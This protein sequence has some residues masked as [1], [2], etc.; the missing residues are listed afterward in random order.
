MKITSGNFNLDLSAQDCFKVAALDDFKVQKGNMILYYSDSDQGK[1]SI[2]FSK[3]DDLFVTNEN[4]VEHKENQSFAAPL[5]H[6]FKE[7]EKSLIVLGI[8]HGVTGKDQTND[9]QFIAVKNIFDN[10]DYK[11]KYLLLI[12]GH[13]FSHGLNYNLKKMNEYELSGDK[14]IKNWQA[15][16]AF[17]A[18][19]LAIDNDIP[20]RGLEPNSDEKA[21]F[22]IHQVG[23]KEID[24]ARY[25]MTGEKLLKGLPFKDNIDFFNQLHTEYQIENNRDMR[26]YFEK[27]MLKEYAFE[28]ITYSEALFRDKFF[29]NVIADQLNDEQ[30]DTIIVI[31]GI[32]HLESEF[33][34]L[35][36]MINIA[37]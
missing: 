32:Y 16:I 8:E 11:K 17:Y 34:T 28:R 24:Y 19:K 27:N 37:N 14:K 31:Y 12:E 2:L 26:T 18:W 36:N 21:G 35:M 20:I 5:M 9:K 13:G 30:Y 25:F 3:V 7:K 6:I 22:L 4:L 15:L 10:L 23:L 33:S 1:V 29:I